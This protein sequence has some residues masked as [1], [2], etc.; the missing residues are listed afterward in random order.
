MWRKVEVATDTINFETSLRQVVEMQLI[1]GHLTEEPMLDVVL[2][3][4]M[5]VAMHGKVVLVRRNDGQVIEVNHRWRVAVRANR[6]GRGAVIS[7]K[8][9]I[10]CEVKPAHGTMV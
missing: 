8:R 3:V 2:T 10:V 4:I 5:E 9:D 6:T 7:K 1:A